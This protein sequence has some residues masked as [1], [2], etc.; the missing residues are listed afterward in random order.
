LEQIIGAVR[1]VVRVA[2][3]LAVVVKVRTASDDEN[4]SAGTEPIH[5]GMP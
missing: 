3:L 2:F 5:A 1:P 4:I